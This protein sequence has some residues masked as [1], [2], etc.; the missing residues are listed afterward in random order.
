[1]AEDNTV[2]IGKKG[3]MNYVLAVITQLSRGTKTVAIKARG[4]SISYA[5]DVAEIVRNKFVTDVKVKDIKI[6]TEVLPNKAGT[7]SNVS[8][9]EI[10]LEK[11]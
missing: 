3:I 1:M 11:P 6:Q 2:Y 10:T 4:S 9:I 7:T 5:V 8:S